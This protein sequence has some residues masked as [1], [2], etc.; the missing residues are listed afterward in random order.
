M[1]LENEI[2]DETSFTNDSGIITEYDCTCLMMDNLER[3]FTSYNPERSFML[4]NQKPRFFFI[5][6]RTRSSTTRRT[7]SPTTCRTR[8]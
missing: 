6:K 1:S 8:I 3:H 7:R 5:N 4:D 2:V